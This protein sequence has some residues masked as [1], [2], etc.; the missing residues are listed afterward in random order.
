MLGGVIGDLETDGIDVGNV[1]LS[2]DGTRVG[3]AADDSPLFVGG[4][5]I[6]YF[7]NVA[8]RTATIIDVLVRDVF[9]NG[10]SFVAIGA[11][12]VAAQVA[13]SDVSSNGFALLTSDGG[14]AGQI[15]VAVSDSTFER[16]GP[17]PSRTPVPNG[18]IGP[19][20]PETVLFQAFGTDSTVVTQLLNL[21]VRGNGTTSG[22]SALGVTFDAHVGTAGIQ[23]VLG[24]T[25]TAGQG[26]NFDERIVS[27]ALFFD[28]CVG[29]LRFDTASGFNAFT[30]PVQ[31]TG[32][33]SLT[34]TTESFD[35]L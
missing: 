18:E 25:Y 15:T 27:T 11:G 30:S 14:A 24:Q 28:T 13:T 6:N 7:T 26:T 33:L 22:L 16:F 21:F 5:G 23:P 17:P 12:T 3:I 9:G 4:T 35:T 32:P 10:I 1:S 29:D 34:I 8:N 20:A 19:F 31:N 2:V